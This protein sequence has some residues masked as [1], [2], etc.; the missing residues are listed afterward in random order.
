M[1]WKYRTR[2][3]ISEMSPFPGDQRLMKMLFR[4]LDIVVMYCVTVDNDFIQMSSSE[5]TT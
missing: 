3:L 4:T 2:L 1:Y 5:M